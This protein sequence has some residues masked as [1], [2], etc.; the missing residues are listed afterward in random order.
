MAYDIDT[1]GNY[2]WLRLSFTPDAI[3]EH[4][5]TGDSYSLIVGDL[6]DEEL[7][8]VGEFALGSPVLYKIF[9]ELLVDGLGYVQPGVP[10]ED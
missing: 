4:F 5:D 10:K 9:H 8:E 2:D 7:A 3:R 1:E 6:T